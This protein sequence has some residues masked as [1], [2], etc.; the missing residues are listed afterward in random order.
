MGWISYSGTTVG[1]VL[2]CAVIQP[3]DARAITVQGEAAVRTDIPTAISAEAAGNAYLALDTAAA[4]P[5]GGWFA[6]YEVDAATAGTY[7]MHAVLT[8]PAIPDRR[9]FGGS[10]F[11]V[12]INGA[13]FIQVARTEPDWADSGP[14]WGSLVSATLNDVELRAGRNSITF[15]VHERRASASPQLDDP[16]GPPEPALYRFFLD[17]F[18]LTPAPLR[19]AHVDLG[20][21][22]TSLGVYRN[23]GADLNFRLNGATADPQT[24]EYTVTNY[25]EHEVA[26]GSARVRAGRRDATA[27]LPELEPGAYSVSASLLSAPGSNVVGRFARLPAQ[28]PVDASTSRFGVTTSS[29]WLVP[30]SRL[31]AFADAM[32]EMGAGYVRE[33]I[34]W[35]QAEPSPG[36]YD[37]RAL[38]RAARGFRRHGLHVLGAW[39]NLAGSAEAPAWAMSDTSMPLPEDLRVAYKFARTVAGRENGIGRDALELWNE[40]E[41]DATASTGDQHA[42]Y[43]KAAALGIRDGQGHALVALPGV[44]GRP[45]AFQDVMLQSDV[46]RYADVW[47]FHV[48]APYRA[49]AMIPFPLAQQVAVQRGLRRLY[50]SRTPQAWATE[51]GIFVIPPGA[52]HDLSTQ[53]QVDQARYLVQ[54]AVSDLA[55]GTDRHFWFSGAPYC[56]NG[57]GCFGLFSGDFQPWPSYSAHAAMASILGEADFVHRVEGLP[58]NALAYTFKNG[59]SVVTVVWA[60]TPTPVAVPVP[61]GSV[62]VYDIMGAAQ[63]SPPVGGGAVQVTATLDPIYIVSDGGAA[64]HARRA[65][66]DRRHGHGSMAERIVLAQRFSAAN[67]GPSKADGGRP[68]VGYQLGDSTRMSVDVYNFNDSPL[69]VTVTGRT[70]GGWSVTGPRTVVVPAKGRVSAPFTVTADDSVH[71]HVDYPLVFDARVAGRDVPP[72]V[73]RIERV[74][75]GPGAP[76]AIAPSITDV[77]PADGETI[78]GDGELT[79]RIRDELTGVDAHRLAV[80]VDGRA[81]R[82]RFDPATGRLSAPLRLA[83]GAHEIWIG[84]RNRA[85]GG[86]QLAVTVRVP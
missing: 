38:D 61:G 49:G 57:F 26:S 31:E 51:S 1:I 83:P 13:P 33:E 63:P 45:A 30:S 10:Q 16:P 5:R 9:P 66:D 75:V 72:S 60:P 53:Q 67:A 34:S 73:A 36:A 76:I 15:M 25:F 14:A 84:A 12:S 3:R 77:S 4:P 62:K 50:G 74:D 80:E 69:A 56:A 41:L 19:L 40:P 58:G 86:S 28:R 20:D 65:I 18:T 22:R 48:Y 32:R 85:Y 70:W 17:E 54:S 42:A 47:A 52:G 39:W 68:P 11:E 35:P 21:P 44:F 24:V 79:A 82:H 59:A 46:A 43:V 8:S 64:L 29:A 7:A 55:A 37:T 6:E 78:P 2:A 71:G 27:R 23:V 81:M